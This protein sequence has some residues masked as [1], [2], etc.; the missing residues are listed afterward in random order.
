M[1]T[2][3]YVATNRVVINAIDAVN[4][5]PAVMVPPL[6]PQ[7]ITYGTAIVDGINIATNAQGVISQIKDVSQGGFSPDAVETLSSPDRDLLVFIH[8]FD[9]TFSDAITRAPLTGNGSLHPRC[10]ERT[11]LL[12][13][14]AGLRRGRRY[15]FQFPRRII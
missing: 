15:L 8:G 9:N 2:T 6:Q 7:Q 12:S 5:Y 1:S 4:G 13:R 14:S 3:V 11:Q 10:R